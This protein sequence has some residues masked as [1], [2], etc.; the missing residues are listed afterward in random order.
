MF[1]L[2]QDLCHCGRLVLL[3]SVVGFKLQSIFSKCMSTQKCLK[4]VYE[5]F[6]EHKTTQASEFLFSID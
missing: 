1:N 2:L 3:L 6:I 5:K 4:S